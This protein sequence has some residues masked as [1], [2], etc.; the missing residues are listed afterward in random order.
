MFDGDIDLAAIVS[1]GS[2]WNVNMFGEC[3]FT[4]RKVGFTVLNELMGRVRMLRQDKD[5]AVFALFSFS[6]FDT[7]PLDCAQG[8]RVLLIGPEE[9]MGRAPAP[10]IE[11][12]MSKEQCD[13]HQKS[14]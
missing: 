12:L 2:Q 14:E 8:S 3:R 1:S 10:T 5:N 9:I 4:R 13:T 11:G 6:G 7:R